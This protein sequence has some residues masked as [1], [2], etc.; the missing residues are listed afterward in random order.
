MKREIKFRAFDDGRMVYPVGAMAN[1]NRFFRVIREDAI[2]M[3]FTGLKDKNGKEIYEGD[4][5]KQDDNT[6][7]GFV[8]YIN[9]SF[10]IEWRGDV[11]A[12]LLGW[13]DYDRG[14]SADG[15][16]LEITGNIYEMKQQKW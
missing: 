8:K 5:I 11:Y 6:L 16:D 10:L 1:I 15:K 14:K 4:V 13:R 3:Q 12:E 2:L 7:I 9:C